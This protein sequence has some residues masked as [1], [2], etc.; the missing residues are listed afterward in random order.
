MYHQTWRFRAKSTLSPEI[1]DVIPVV[2]GQIA[3]IWFAMIHL[4]W[5][6][7]GAIGLPVSMFRNAELQDESLVHEVSGI[8]FKNILLIRNPFLLL[9]K[10]V[11]SG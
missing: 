10:C 11:M 4:P 5:L 2:G 1:P 9:K 7:V 3:T 8:S 6:H